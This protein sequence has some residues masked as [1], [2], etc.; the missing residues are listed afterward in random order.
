MAKAA[1]TNES[2]GTTQILA[3]LDPATVSRTFT[4]ATLGI[5]VL[6]PAHARVTYAIHTGAAG[7][8]AWRCYDPCGVDPMGW[9][10]AMAAKSGLMEGALRSHRHRCPTV[11]DDVPDERPMH[12]SG[13]L[14]YQAS[15]SISARVSGSLMF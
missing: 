10:T 13:P 2:A 9:G 8:F 5:N 14:L 7:T 11:V 3:A 15:G 6:I 1:T 12:S 4:V